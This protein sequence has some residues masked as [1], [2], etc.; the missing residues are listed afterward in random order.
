MSCIVKYFLLSF[1][2]FQYFDNYVSFSK[3]YYYYH[4]LEIEANL[5]LKEKELEDILGQKKT[6]ESSS[7]GTAIFSLFIIMRSMT[8]EYIPVVVVELRIEICLCCD[9]CA[10]I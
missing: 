3:F 9:L 10:F 2:H 5:R 7:E 8:G 1:C 4:L 6:A